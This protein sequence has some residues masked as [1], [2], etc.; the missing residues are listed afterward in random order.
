M[1]QAGYNSE[2]NSEFL[3][4]AGHPALAGVG[5]PSN[6]RVLRT[7]SLCGRTGK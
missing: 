4:D 3:K 6:L 5:S 2:I 1:G 7:N